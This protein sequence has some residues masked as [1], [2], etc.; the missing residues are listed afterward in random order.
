MQK[1][2][3]ILDEYGLAH[4]ISY[5]VTEKLYRTTDGENEYALKQSSFTVDTTEQWQSF[6]SLVEKYKIQS[7][8]P[9]YLTES[10]APFVIHDGNLFYLS[11]WVTSRRPLSYEDEFQSF[12]QAIGKVHKKTQQSGMIT[13]ERLTEIVTYFQSV[14]DN[15]SSSLLHAVEQFEKERFMSPFG[16]LVCTQFRNIQN[17]LH[18]TREKTDYLMEKIKSGAEWRI[19]LTHGNLRLSHWIDPY[20][21]NWEQATYSSPVV[22]LYTFFT[23][24]LSSQQLFDV[25]IG[26]FPVYLRESELE[27]HELHL[28][29]LYLL[30]PQPYLRLVQNYIQG[31][32]STLQSIYHLQEAYRKIMFGLSFQSFVQ[33]QYEPLMN[34]EE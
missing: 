23:S 34:N 15:T 10:Q 2:D 21:I 31:E 25:F 20:F 4:A 6:L 19:C 12:Y 26:Q 29:S 7:F 27:E 24:E 3:R 5:P 13:T 8:L 9:V 17:T 18:R 32:T 1:I 22:D 14:Y 11:P 28:L 30:N 16:L 33:Q